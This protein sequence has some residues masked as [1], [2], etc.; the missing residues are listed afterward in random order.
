M[1]IEKVAHE[2]PEKIFKVTIDPL[3]GAQAYQGR[4]VA[5]QLGLNATQTKQFVK[6]YLGL[7][8]MFEECDLAM[9]EVN[10]LV[11]TKEGNLHCL[12]AK[13]VVDSNAIFRQP[14]LKG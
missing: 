2:T 8:K 11:V 1:E 12:D 4:E 9:I 7:A 5:G 3:I 6:I 13:I 14:K 10:P